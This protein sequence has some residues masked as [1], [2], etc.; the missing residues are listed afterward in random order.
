MLSVIVARRVLGYHT[1]ADP[2]LLFGPQ[3]FNTSGGLVCNDSGLA[4]VASVSVVSRPDGHRDPLNP[5]TRTIS[6]LFRRP[7]EVQPVFYDVEVPN[8][9]R[10]ASP[11]RELLDLNPSIDGD[12]IPSTMH[13]RARTPFAPTSYPDY[14][15]YY[16]P[17]RHLVLQ[18]QVPNPRLPGSS[19]G[20]ASAADLQS[21][22]TAVAHG[23]LSPITAAGIA[24]R[25]ANFLTDKYYYMYRLYNFEYA[26]RTGVSGYEYYLLE[27]DGSIKDGIGAYVDQVQLIM[28]NNVSQNATLLA[29]VRRDTLLP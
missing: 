2:L 24:D 5:V 20:Y 9:L 8:M 13:L 15:F 12:K 25:V 16:L 7:F 27:Q 19:L 6:M 18:G 1:G 22:F 23:L 26:N 4:E 21:A 11:R 3:C 17:V 28:G 29:T 14:N 10:V